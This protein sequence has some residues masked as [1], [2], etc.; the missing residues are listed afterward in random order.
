[1]KRQGLVL[2]LAEKDIREAREWYEEKRPG[3]GG[4]FLLAVDRL[5]TR[6][7]A[8]KAG[9]GES[10]DRNPGAIF[11]WLS[12]GEPGGASPATAPVGATL[13]AHSQDIWNVASPDIC[14]MVAAGGGVDVCVG[15]IGVH[16]STGFSLAP[17]AGPPASARP[18]VA[19]RTLVC[20]LLCAS[21]S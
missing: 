18:L 21:F 4:E 9:T 12:R 11:V 15:G 8:G 20:V 13:S 3:L 1:V 5:L 16:R 19:Q 14:N 17:L 2:P 7:G 10:G 6:I